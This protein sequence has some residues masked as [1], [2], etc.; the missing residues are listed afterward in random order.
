MSRP[1][2]ICRRASTFS[3]RVAQ[4]RCT[5]WRRFCSHWRNSSSNA[6]TLGRPLASTT[7]RLILTFFSSSVVAKRCAMSSSWSTRL[8]RVSSLMATGLS[9][10]ASSRTSTN[11]GSFLP[12]IC[13]AICSMILLLV[14]YGG[15]ESMMMSL[16][17][18]TQLARNLMLPTPRA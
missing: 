18:L 1:A 6:M 16:L 5:C 11:C 9:A 12:S 8:E 15:N 17:S 4:R 3:R 14:Q 10:S 13:L 7:L 2:R